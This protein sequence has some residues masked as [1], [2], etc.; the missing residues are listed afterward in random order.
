MDVRDKQ[1]SG[2]GG[3]RDSLRHSRGKLARG[4]KHSEDDHTRYRKNATHPPRVEACDIDGA[5]LGLLPHQKGGD[6]LAGD[7]KEDIHA[8][9]ASGGRQP[10]MMQ[11]HGT[12]GNRLQAIDLPLVR[13]AQ[14]VRSAEPRLA[15]NAPTTGRCRA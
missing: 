5:M 7:D 9:V 4:E 6:Q 8:D 15:G 10:C 1:R 13:N 12:H 2:D 14:A 11:D 3:L